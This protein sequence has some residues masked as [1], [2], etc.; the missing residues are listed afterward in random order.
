LEEERKRRRERRRQCPSISETPSKLS[1]EGYYVSKHNN[2]K[3]IT[4]F[5]YMI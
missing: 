4:F 1:A 3:K 2:G 5:T